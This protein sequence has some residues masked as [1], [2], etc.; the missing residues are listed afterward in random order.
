MLQV[1][2]FF[3]VSLI[4]GSSASVV[5]GIRQVEY[6]CVFLYISTKKNTEEHISDA[7]GD[8]LRPCEERNCEERKEDVDHGKDKD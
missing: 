4:V 8:D 6:F 5:Y 2:F 3:P 7:Q 1:G